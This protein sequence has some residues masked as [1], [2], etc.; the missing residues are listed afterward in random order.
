MALDGVF[1]GFEQFM[2]EIDQHYVF[3]IYVSFSNS[4]WVINYFE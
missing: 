3:S 4:N 2:S 1:G